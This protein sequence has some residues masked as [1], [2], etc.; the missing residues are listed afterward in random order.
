[1]K[2]KERKK[3]LDCELELSVDV[4]PTDGSIRYSVLITARLKE[5][6]RKCFHVDSTRVL[7]AQ[8]VSWACVP[9]VSFDCAALSGAIALLKCLWRNQW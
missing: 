4:F 1:M 5:S 6:G 9:T 7:V 3:G 8:W 2:E